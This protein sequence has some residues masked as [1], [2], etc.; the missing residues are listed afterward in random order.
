MPADG[1]RRL[2]VGVRILRLLSACCRRRLMVGVR[3]LR[4]L[5]ASRVVVR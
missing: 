3:I 4:L 5:S 1:R 2:M